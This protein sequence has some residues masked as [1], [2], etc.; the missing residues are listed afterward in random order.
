MK[1]SIY[2]PHTDTLSTLDLHP[3]SM[4]DAENFGF[5]LR[6][7]LYASTFANKEVTDALARAIYRY[8]QLVAWGSEA[9]IH[10]HAK[11]VRRCGEW[12]LVPLV[13]E[14]GRFLAGSVVA[15]V[16]M[17]GKR[18]LVTVAAHVVDECGT[19]EHFG[20]VVGRPFPMHELDNTAPSTSLTRLVR[21]AHGLT[22]SPSMR[23]YLRNRAESMPMGGLVPSRAS[24][25]RWLEA[26]EEEETSREKALAHPQARAEELAC[27]QAR[28]E[29]LAYPQT[30]E[31]TLAYQQTRA[32]AL[33]YQQ[34]RDEALAC[35][36]TRAE[37]LAHQQARE[38]TLAYQRARSEYL[39]A[40]PQVPQRA[41]IGGA[42]VNTFGALT[43]IER[44]RTIA[45]TA[46][47]ELA[48]EDPDAVDFA[49]FDTKAAALCCGREELLAW[50]RKHARLL[51]CLPTPATRRAVEAS[52]DEGAEL[53]LG[54]P[55]YSE[56]A[57]TMSQTGVCRWSADEAQFDEDP[58]PEHYR[59]RQRCLRD[60]GIYV[61]LA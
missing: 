9:H 11:W 6:E 40:P 55:P 42:S 47:R 39:N 5:L 26:A 8:H 20:L 35:P 30:R 29:A 17:D 37:A 13:A 23:T 3:G 16:R 41:R 60:L 12:V 15:A 18:S 28:D 2:A 45:N 22:P 56:P 54:L 27:Q 14:R 51:L 43:R 7:Y 33:A 24:F 52:K 58:A 31:E 53:A 38:E 21:A 49:A 4:T 48:N 25:D 34:A 57:P 1:P 44:L 32:E 61:P 50:W 59:S 19:E 46:A 10:T 36:Q